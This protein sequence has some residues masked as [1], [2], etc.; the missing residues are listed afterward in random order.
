M[1]NDDDDDDDDDWGGGDGF[2]DGL[3]EDLGCSGRDVVEPAVVVD[4]S[5]AA[6]VDPA[7]NDDP[8]NRER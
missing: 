3:D 2:D 5:V 6:A 4:V 7:V 8:A 1:R